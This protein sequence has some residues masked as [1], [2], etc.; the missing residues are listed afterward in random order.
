MRT[1]VLG[2]IPL[3]ALPSGGKAVDSRRPMST[4]S[5]VLPAPVS[6]SSRALGPEAWWVVGILLL[7]LI[8]RTAVVGVRS[9]E[10]NVER[11]A[12][13]GM[14]QGI[15]D[16]RGLSVPGTTQPTAF[17]PP[18]YPLLLAPISAPEQAWLRGLL[19]VVL[20]TATAGL[21]WLI[22]RR[23]LDSAR[24]ARLAAGFVAIDP[25][26]LL[27][28]PQI[29]TETLATFLAAA[30]LTLLTGEPA[31]WSRRRQIAIGF[32]L[33]LACLCRPTFL[34]WTAALACWTAVRVLAGQR[35]E[36]DVESWSVRLRHLPWLILVA[37]VLTIAPW[38]IRNALRMGRPVVTTTHGGYTLLLSN[39]PAYDAEV[40][41]A[42]TGGVWSGPSL[43]RWQ[44]DLQSEM[45][46]QGIS[47]ELA[48][49][50]WMK[51][52]ALR[53]IADHPSR[54]VAACGQRFTSLWRILPGQESVPVSTAAW[55]VAVF[56][57][58]QWVLALLGLWN[59]RGALTRFL[60]ALLLIV[61]ISAT[62]AVYFSNARMRAPLVPVLAILAAKGLAGLLRSPAN[63]NSAAATAGG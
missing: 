62:H 18:L 15:R 25:L 8:S 35:Q 59:L 45:A 27:Y 63:V 28:T 34:P 24:E 5:P 49:D 19:Q 58:T 22:A 7:A 30:A 21:T 42:G 44:R 43:D 3:F 38:P 2:C 50:E 54:F 20:G 51:A 6:T 47:G 13:L 16:G 4:A 46:A 52:A 53:W 36:A 29:M 39:N 56:Y 33:G 32:V 37:I 10:L 55:G 9:A 14:A 57:G 40:V 41:R 17:R 23:L 61:T 48:Q 1:P 60:P 11:D 31:G 26:L 12:Y